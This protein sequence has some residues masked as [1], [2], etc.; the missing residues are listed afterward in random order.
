VKLRYWA[1][2]VLKQEKVLLTVKAQENCSP[3][4]C[5]SGEKTGE[6]QP[7]PTLTIMPNVLIGTVA[8]A[9]TAELDAEAASDLAKWTKGTG[10][11][12]A[13]EFLLNQGVEH[14][15]STALTTMFVLE[16]ELPVAGAAI[17]REYN[18]LNREE[19][20]FMALILNAFKVRARGLGVTSAGV[21]TRP[22]PIPG[23]DFLVP[24][25][26]DNGPFTIDPGGLTW[27]YGQHLAQ[28]VRLG[29]QTMHLRVYEVSYCIQGLECGP[30]YSGVLKQRYDGIRAYLYFEFTADR[31][32]ADAR[33]S[34]YADSFI[35]PY[36]AE[37]WMQ[38]QFGG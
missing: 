16:A 19:L 21:S 11:S 4:V 2:G 24:F 8:E 13:K 14:L 5:P 23:R 28:R 1:P 26:A 35:V 29:V 15:I 36:S 30:G 10:A 17:L 38:S 33:H 37:A 22:G 6:A 20:G 18:S 34:V 27:Q 25:A 3:K 7:N 31:G 32:A 9:K 12:R